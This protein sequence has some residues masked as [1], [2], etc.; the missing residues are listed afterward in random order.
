[1]IILFIVLFIIAARFGTLLF[2]AHKRTPHKK[3][4][5]VYEHLVFHTL[6]KFNDSI[7]PTDKIG[8]RLKNKA[9]S[10]GGEQQ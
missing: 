4:D 7:E 5:G 1:M 2:A 8:L 6:T 3:L 10:L 9:L